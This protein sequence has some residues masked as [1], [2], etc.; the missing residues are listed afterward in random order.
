MEGRKYIGSH[1]EK[2]NDDVQNFI[3]L[4]EIGHG[5][6]KHRNPVVSMGYTNEQIAEIYELER[7]QG[8][9]LGQEFEADEYAA[10]ITG[11]DVALVALMQ[12]MMKFKKMLEYC[13]EDP[14][15]FEKIN[16]G[17]EEI[18]K[19]IENIKQTSFNI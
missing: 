10:K 12:F 2:Y 15:N 11:K 5:E 14:D 1:F 6:L 17:I 4:H 3:L 13:K 9:Y 16:K 8:K 18:E 7:L 19:R